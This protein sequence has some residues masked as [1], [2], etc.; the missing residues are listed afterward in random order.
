MFLKSSSVAKRFISVK[1]SYNSLSEINP[2]LSLSIFMNS[3]CNFSNSLVE[4]IF[5]SIFKAALF[6]PDTAL[7]YL[8]DYII[9]G[10]SLAASASSFI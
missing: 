9:V 1:A 3:L 7:N 2:V 5:T 10:F 8:K 6:I 4:I